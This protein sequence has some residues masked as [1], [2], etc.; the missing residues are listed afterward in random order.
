M[1]VPG[2]FL[3]IVDFILEIFIGSGLGRTAWIVDAP[4]EVFVMTTVLH[5]V[6]IPLTFYGIYILGFSKKSYKFSMI[7][8][9][10]IE[11]FSYLI[12]D[13]ETNL[14]CIKYSCDLDYLQF[15]PQDLEW[16]GTVYYFIYST[17]LSK[18]PV[19]NT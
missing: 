11:S 2:Q 18:R 15:D 7:F 19:K 14:N 6:T 8:I 16:F 12:S 5:A 3:W 13:M 4:L 10:I 9:I 17:L 1:A